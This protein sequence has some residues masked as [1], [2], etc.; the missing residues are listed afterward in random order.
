MTPPRIFQVSARHHLCGED[1]GQPQVTLGAIDEA[2]LAT[3]REQGFDWL[4]LYGV[5]DSGL[6]G[7]AVSRAHPAFWREQLGHLP[8]GSTND[9]SGSPFAIRSYQV[10]PRLGTD[11]ELDQLRDRCHKAGLFLMLDFVVNHTALDHPWLNRRPEWYIQAKGDSADTHPGWF[12]PVG[13]EK[14]PR[15]IAHGRDPYFPSWLDTAQLNLFHPELIQAH[16]DCLLA[17]A[18][19]CDG[20]RCDMAMLA[21]GDVFR[22]TWGELADPADG[23]PCTDTAFWEY[24]IPRLKSRFPESVL[25]AEAYWDLESRLL[26][27]GFDLAYDKPMLDHLKMGD[28]RAV[29]NHLTKTASQWNHLVRFTENHD[30]H[31]MASVFAPGRKEAAYLLT[32]LHGGPVLV[33]DGQSQGRKLDAGIHLARRAPEPLDQEIGELTKKWIQVRRE[34]PGHHQIRL[35]TR[36][37]WMDN[38]SHEQMIAWVEESNTRR[39]LVCVNFAGHPSQG[40][41]IPPPGW[42]SG[43]GW[44]L[45]DLYQNRQFFAPPDDLAA[46]GLFVDLPAW[47]IHLFVWDR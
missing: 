13:A 39:L 20:L 19:R 3:I 29:R 15:L 14:G 23:S 2:W 5:W 40:R 34:F 25:C 16:S 33:H 44:N 42:I 11:A 43:H 24:A 12:F 32:W 31:R 35:E 36:P 27:I 8:Q 9:V 30:E 17:A 10:D 45:T 28:G 26:G 1:P 38:T 7:R 47:G 6:M 37:P 46:N 21:L 22:S 18:S 41:L 4:Y